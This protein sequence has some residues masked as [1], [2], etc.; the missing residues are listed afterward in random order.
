LPALAPDPAPEPTSRVPALAPVPRVAAPAPVPPP[1]TS[2]VPAL[3]R[4][5]YASREAAPDLDA[6]SYF[7]A[8]ALSR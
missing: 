1:R 3:V 4:P 5:R 6:L 7:A 2:L 8:E